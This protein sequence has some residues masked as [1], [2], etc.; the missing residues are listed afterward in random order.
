MENFKKISKQQLLRAV[1]KI[2][3]IYV[4][5]LYTVE[6][7][8]D[9]TLKSFTPAV[10]EAKPAIKKR[11]VKTLPAAVVKPI[12]SYIE[13][14][15]DRGTIEIQ[16][17]CTRRCF[18]FLQTRMIYR[19]MR[20]RPPGEIETAVEEIF[21][22]CGWDEVS[23]HLSVSPVII[24]ASTNWWVNYPNIIRTFLYLCPACT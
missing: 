2:E 15:H 23:L 12:V 3:G 21:N 7:E 4:P 24:R 5:G 16:R 10:P 22:N 18:R 14:I 6:Y 13:T 8:P 1:A 20:V 9:G 11:I 19:P 17:G